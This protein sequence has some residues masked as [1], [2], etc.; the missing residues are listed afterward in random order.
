MSSQIIDLRAGE[1]LTNRVKV[2]DLL[3]D[4]DDFIWI[5]NYYFD[6][7]HFAILGEVLS[8]GINLSEI[9]LL[10]KPNRSVTDLELLK[11]YCKSFKKQYKFNN[12]Q[13]KI[14]THS[15]IS[16]SIHDR[17]FY[18]EKQVWN[19]IE[20]DS[21]L[22]NQRATISLLPNS[23]Y[24]KNKKEFEFWWNHDGTHNI[25][26]DW[27]ILYEKIKKREE[28]MKT[29]EE[30][31]LNEN[32]QQ[33]KNIKNVFYIYKQNKGIVVESKEEKEIGIDEALY[34]LENLQIE[35]TKKNDHNLDT[36]HYVG[37]Q[38]SVTK[39]SIQ[40]LHKSDELWYVELP[41][42]NND[43]KWEGYVY[44]AYDNLKKMKTLLRSSFH[45]H[46]VLLD[47]NILEW[48][49]TRFKNSEKSLGELIDDDKNMW[50][51]LT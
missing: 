15:D 22:R 46:S 20:L 3:S 36:W 35:T 31:S 13:I 49:V 50:H 44:Y 42:L 47:N 30:I 40:F 8:S 51:D 43:L 37:F 24:E 23:D 25:F 29:K 39:Q 26:D 32:S 38:N 2:I 28:S 33:N 5:T 34:E 14:I 48:K 19:F 10:F 12:I 41:L 27:K 45:N 21:L 16:H 4:A 1:N 18:H 9:R 7:H 17:F 6:R 11:Q